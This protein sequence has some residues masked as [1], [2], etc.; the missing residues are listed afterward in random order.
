MTWLLIIQ[1]VVVGLLLLFVLGLLRGYAELMREVHD[2][3]VQMAGFPPPNLSG[4]QRKAPAVISG[5]GPG[6]EARQLSISGHDSKVLLA[7][8]SST[9]MTCSTFLESLADLVMPEP[10]DKVVVVREPP[11]DSPDEVARR[12]K[13]GLVVIA[14]D[15]AYSLFKV[16]G[17]PYFVLVDGGS[18]AV[19]G[20]GTAASL[21]NLRALLAGYMGYSAAGMEQLGG[22][23]RAERTE[24]I[25][26]AALVKEGG[27]GPWPREG[28][29]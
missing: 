22:R 12:V 7:F 23:A 10:L 1:C 27:T 28:R 4:Q 9:C 29:E 14:S 17:T 3:K 6:G 18:G 5:K 13:G 24:R 26:G 2:I 8:L 11:L 15:E 16:M 25:V 21:A 19:L 20:Q